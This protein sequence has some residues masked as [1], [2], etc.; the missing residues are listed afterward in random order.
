MI[1][2]AKRVCCQ[3]AGEDVPRVPIDPLVFMLAPRPMMDAEYN[4]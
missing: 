4:L 2:L 3:L 1:Y